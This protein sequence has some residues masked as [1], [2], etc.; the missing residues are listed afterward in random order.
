MLRLQL[1]EGQKEKLLKLLNKCHLSQVQI[2][3]HY[4]GF[5]FLQWLEQEAEKHR[6]R[7]EIRKKRKAERRAARKAKKKGKL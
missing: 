6:L 1:H 5:F 4:L 2:Q 7:K 3:D